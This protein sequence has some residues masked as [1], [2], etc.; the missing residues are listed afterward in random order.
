MK[1]QKTCNILSQGIFLSEIYRSSY[2]Q[3]YIEKTKF[4]KPFYPLL[5]SIYIT[6]ILYILQKHSIL[7]SFLSAN[8][9]ATTCVSTIFG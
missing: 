9:L 1:S 4:V 8:S 5:V 3:Q 6:Q 7:L 2:K